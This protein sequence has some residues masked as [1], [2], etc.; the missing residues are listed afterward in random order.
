[1][2]DWLL[3]GA[4]IHFQLMLGWTPD[5]RTGMLKLKR[6]RPYLD[7][8][9]LLQERSTCRRRPQGQR[10]GRGTQWRGGRRLH[11]ASVFR[12]TGL[13][14]NRL[15]L[16]VCSSGWN[17]GRPGLPKSQNFIFRWARNYILETWR[18]AK[19]IYLLIRG[20]TGGRKALYFN[21]SYTFI[22]YILH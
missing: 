22:N 20:N 3:L 9:F 4:W 2:L 14:G 15:S 18:A 7:R 10:T 13:L 1:M 12:W 8:S 6:I 19:V 11:L 21:D 17:C 5:N 16:E